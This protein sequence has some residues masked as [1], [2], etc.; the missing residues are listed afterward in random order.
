MSFLFDDMA[1]TLA[2]P[3]PRRRALGAC[4]RLLL[5]GTALGFLF[6]QEAD[7]F[8]LAC[9]GNTLIG[10]AKPNCSAAL[11]NCPATGACPANCP[12]QHIQDTCNASFE[13]QRNVQCCAVGQCFCAGTNTCS[14][15]VNMVCAAGCSPA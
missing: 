8:A 1:R 2:T 6:R 11:M 7:A 10:P 15:S 12:Q 9:G 3:M 13:C 4:A 5:G 14:N